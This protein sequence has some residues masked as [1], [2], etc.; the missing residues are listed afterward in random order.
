MLDKIEDTI[1][2]GYTISPVVEAP[3]I[4]QLEFSNAGHGFLKQSALETDYDSFRY[5][6]CDFGLDKPSWTDF[7]EEF[8]KLVA[9]ADANTRYKVLFLARHGQGWHN[10]TIEKYSEP[11]WDEH[12]CMLYGNDEITWGPDPELTELGVNQAKANN[13]EWKN[14]VTKGVPLPQAFYVSPFT[15]SID[16]MLHTWDGIMLNIEEPQVAPPLVLED[17]REDIGIHTCD[18]RNTRSYIAK[19]YPH[20]VIEKGLTETDE[21]HSPHVRETLEQHNVRTR[22]FLNRL[23]AW[24]W[25]TPNPHLYVSVTS[26]SGTNISFL[27]VIGHRPFPLETGGMI[28]VVVKATKP[29]L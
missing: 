7:K 11:Y 12:L 23:F 5:L 17:L 10:Y 14:Q 3:E 24:D 1:G 15:R 29:S 28:P 20:L 6:E 18:E 9:S 13:R 21:L 4:P 27:D 2:G 16:T 8:E 25:D 22:R 26:H 19:K